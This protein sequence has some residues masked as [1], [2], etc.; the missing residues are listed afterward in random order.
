M[1]RRAIST[2]SLMSGNPSLVSDCWIW[3]KITSLVKE[4]LL[5]ISNK[6]VEWEGGATIFVSGFDDA[7]LLPNFNGLLLLEMSISKV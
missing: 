3:G 2:A 7:L 6:Q 4:Q 1:P 5:R